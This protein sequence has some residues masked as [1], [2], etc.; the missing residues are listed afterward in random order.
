MLNKPRQYTAIVIDDE[1]L[2][3]KL[4]RELVNQYCSGIVILNDYPDIIQGE[5]AIRASKP[6]IVFLDINMPGGNGFDLLDRFSKS[7]RDFLLV[8]ITG[9]D[10]YGI[11]AVK[12]GAFD[13]LLKPIDIDE[14]ITLSDKIF[15]HFEVTPETSN[16]FISVFTNREREILS[17]SDI[18]C[19]EANGSYSRIYLLDGSERLVSKNVTQLMIELNGLKI[20][21][22][23][24]S[25]AINPALVKSYR[26]SGGEF[27]VE[28][29]NGVLAKVSRKFKKEF[30]AYVG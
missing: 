25:F 10:E 24:R 4:I 11:R 8:F 30:K 13:Y 1:T 17:E 9:H 26:V 3:R 18:V 29:S 28:L 20:K 23:H 19:I 14:L 22:V 5:A 6:D 27:E 21:R 12:S 2:D 16:A 15:D 7:H